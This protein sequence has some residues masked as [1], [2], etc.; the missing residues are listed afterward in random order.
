MKK[1]K[2]RLPLGTCP[3]QG[4]FQVRFPPDIPRQ[5]KLLSLINVSEREQ[6]SYEC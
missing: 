5:R 6:Y 2:D 4:F 3:L 1:Q